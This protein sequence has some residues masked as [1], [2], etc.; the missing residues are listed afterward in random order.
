MGCDESKK[1]EQRFKARGDFGN[2][3]ER[4]ERD[5]VHLGRLPDRPVGGDCVKSLRN[6]L[7]R[8]TQAGESWVP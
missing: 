8:T 5:F 7:Q 4:V 6:L 1:E 2:Y 3:G